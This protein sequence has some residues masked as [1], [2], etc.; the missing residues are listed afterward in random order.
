MGSIFH[1]PLARLSEAEFLGLR[2]R[3]PGRVVG[4]HLEGSVDYRKG[5][6][7]PPVLLVMGNEQSGLSA[8]IAAACDQLVRIPMAGRADSLNLAVATAV[9]LY[10]IR[11]PVFDAGG[12]A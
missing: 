7:R 9:M 12:G 10:E 1:V 6:Y 2:R 3:W 5:D 11:R 8:T 4:T